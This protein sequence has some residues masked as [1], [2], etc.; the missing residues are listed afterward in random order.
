MKRIKRIL[1]II[2]FSFL[3]TGCTLFEDNSM[4]NIEVYTTIYPYNYLIYYLYGNNS[5]INSIYPNSIDLNNYKLSEKKLLEYSKCDLFVFSSLDEKERNYAAKMINNNKKLKLIDVSLGMM[6]NKSIEETWLNPYNYLMMAKNVK[7]GLNEYIDN[8]ILNSS[9]NT[10]YEELQYEISNLDASI[11]ETINNASYDTILTSNDAL[12]FLEKYGLKV[13]SIENKKNIEEAK[14]HI[15]DGKIKY[16]FSLSNK[17]DDI[18]E[19]IDDTNVEII[20]LNS[21]NN[22]NSLT[23]SSNDNYFNIMNENLELINKELEK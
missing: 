10:S 21:M 18:K 4:D 6:I 13:I 22:I 19:F 2:L 11:K 9:I 20:T 5:K 17:N 8:K 1:T 16:L 12:L 3:L 14:K 15:N 23:E 7:D